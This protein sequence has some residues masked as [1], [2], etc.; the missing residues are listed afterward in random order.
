[1]KLLHTYRSLLVLSLLILLVQGMLCMMLLP[2]V[3]VA[4]QVFLVLITLLVQMAIF[5][6]CYLKQ[7]GMFTPLYL[8]KE[9]D[10]GAGAPVGLQRGFLFIDMNG[11][12]T[13]AE[14]L[15]HE[16]YS[17][18]LCDCYRLL[19][20]VLATQT[21]YHIYQFVGDEAIVYWDYHCEACTPKALLIIEAYN[22]LLRE[23]SHYFRSRYGL[24]PSF[25]YA[26]H[27]GGVTRVTLNA[28]GGQM[29]FHGDVL[30][31]CSRLLSLCHQHDTDL[32][33]S[34]AYHNKLGLPARAQL[35]RIDNALLHGKSSSLT[36]YK[37]STS[38]L[39]SKHHQP[40][41]FYLSKK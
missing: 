30:N 5:Y 40:A 39:A 2:L 41:Q 8:P 4:I 7:R 16:R 3:P 31:T 14:Q 24:Q 34:E 32:I 25:K 12:T 29:A 9:H 1:M 22:A 23:Q 28:P 17:A 37:R 10:G 15:K 33:V 11:S 27:G 21:G 19:Q 35:S 38:H 26:I 36:V 20:R 18:L 6:A 13:V